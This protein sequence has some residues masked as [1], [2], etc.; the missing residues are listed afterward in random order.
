MKTF[1]R[2]FL[3]TEDGATAVE[4]VL[5]LPILLSMVFGIICFGQ[6][7][8]IANSLQQLAAEA[9]RYSAIEFQQD[10]RV[11]AANTF[12]TEADARFTFL[13]QDKVTYTTVPLS[14]PDGIQVS[15]TYDLQGSAVALAGGFIGIDFVTLTRS[16]YIAY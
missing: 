9:A 1:T 13:A 7:F 15:L 16:S 6:Y 5:V 3:K 8:A 4:F 10:D 11:A 12:I 14:D 2:H